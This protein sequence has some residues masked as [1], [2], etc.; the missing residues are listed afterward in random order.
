VETKYRKGKMM[1]KRIINRTSTEASSSDEGSLDLERL[2]QVE[3]TSEDAAHP[4][5]SALTTGSGAGWRASESGE[6]TVRLV[7]DEPQRLSRISLVFDEDSERRTQ[8][9]VIRVSADNGRSYWEVLRQ[10]FTF[11]PGTTREIEDYAVN[12][13]AVTILELR[14][15]PDISGGGARASLTRLRLA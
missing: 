1:R 11:G 15:I 2:A 14:V 5:E 4:I 7:F 9:F 13:D 3:I 8:E 10:Q 6:Q 12:L